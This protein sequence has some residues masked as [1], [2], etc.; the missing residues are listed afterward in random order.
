M[1]S[2]N[3]RVLF[4]VNI[5]HW[6]LKVVPKVIFFNQRTQV[7]D[8]YCWH[9]VIDNKDMVLQVKYYLNN[10]VKYWGS[11]YEVVVE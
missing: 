5:L 7:V 4:D 3:N 8:G 11:C 10:I 9:I 6:E 1:G 2:V